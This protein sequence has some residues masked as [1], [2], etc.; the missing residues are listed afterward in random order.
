MECSWS[1][2]R[3]FSEVVGQAGYAVSIRRSV[4][5]DLRLV[6]TTESEFY[7]QAAVLGVGTLCLGDQLNRRLVEDWNL[8][9]LNA[10]SGNNCVTITTD[11]K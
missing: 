2:T 4:K 6:M 10:V 9:T 8:R 1:R 7:A 11:C 3:A 5:A